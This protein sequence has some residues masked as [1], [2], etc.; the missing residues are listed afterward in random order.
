MRSY[1]HK[2]HSSLF[3]AME[4]NLGKDKSREFRKQALPIIIIIIKLESSNKFEQYR[5]RNPQNMAPN[6]SHEFLDRL[7]KPQLLRISFF[8]RDS[9]IEPSSLVPRR[10]SSTVGGGAHLYSTCRL[11][12]TYIVSTYLQLR[13]CMYENM[14]MYSS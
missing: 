2:N 11:P 8:P 14:Y 10:R 7:L 6:F 9:S 3:L 1:I 5:P 13:V 12:T 4:E